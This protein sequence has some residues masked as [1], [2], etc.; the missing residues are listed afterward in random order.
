MYKNKQLTLIIKYL[1]KSVTNLTMNSQKF[2]DNYINIKKAPVKA[3]EP[4]FDGIPLSELS[5]LATQ[6][7]HGIKCTLGQYG[8][9]IFHSTSNSGKTTFRTQMWLDES[10]NKL[11]S[12]GTHYPGQWKSSADRF[13]ELYNEKYKK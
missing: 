9:L 2:H 8:E 4:V 6:C 10:T 13:V 5:S 7:Y 12:S 3:A 1:C 11:V